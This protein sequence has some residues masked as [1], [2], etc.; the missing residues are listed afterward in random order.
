MNEPLDIDEA[1]APAADTDR[2]SFG[3]LLTYSIPATG[4][5]YMYFMAVLYLMKFSTDVLL[6]APAVVSVILGLSRVMDAVTDP[7]AG[8]L[9][10]RTRSR[11]GRRRPW[12]IFSAVPIALVFVMMWAPPAG[13]SGTALTLWMA[14]AI[15]GFYA[16]ITLVN[17]PHQSWGAELSPAHHERTR[18]FGMRLL[19]LNVGAFMA[20]GSLL[21]IGRAEDERATVL[22]LAA[23]IG[24]FTAVAVVWSALRLRERV[25]LQ[26]RGPQAVLGAYRDVLS[27]PHA[28]LLLIVFFIESLGSATIGV[29]TAYMAQYVIG[30]IS[31]PLVV[32]TYFVAQTLS[33]PAW[34]PLSR[35]FGKK[36]LWLYA[37][38]ASA[39]GFGMFFFVGPG[40][41]L[42]T[43]AL[44][45]IVG[46][47]GGCGNV[48][49]PSVQ[50]DIVDW[51]ELQTG[52]RKEGGYFAAFNFTQ[53]SA[54]GVTIMLTGIVLQ[55]SGYVPN[56][57]QAE[58][59]KLAIQSLYALF[60]L[61]CYLIGS[62]LFVRFS[63]NETEHDE[64]RR[65]L[66]AR[67]VAASI[68]V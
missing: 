55:F 60:P 13:L 58:S 20:I 67:R 17:V 62:L 3:T 7:I 40:D 11:M 19:L 21:L 49:A 63:L 27:N 66:E 26:G 10:D 42:L 38:V 33:V 2:L 35:L 15:I 30:D 32:L 64:V 37:M 61:V 12:L 28:R 16:I 47:A 65:Q 53:K 14:V 52:E 5:G 50:S 56:V 24:A 48:I 54:S 25:E 57:E 34:T 22:A 31:F 1:T 68:G 6:I 18:V 9:S 8:Y 39:L 36:R 51:D 59:A 44:A 4:L 46:A 29:L 23:G 43:Y 41:I 45:A